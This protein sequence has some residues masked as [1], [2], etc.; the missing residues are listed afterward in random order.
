MLTFMCRYV[1]TAAQRTR[2]GAQY[3]SA[4]TCAS[5]APRTTGT[6]VS[7]SPLCAPPT[8][9]VRPSTH[10]LRTGADTGQSGN[11]I[12][13]ESLRWAAT[14]APPSTS[15]RTVVRQRLPAKTTRPNTPAM[16]RPSTRRN[17]PGAALRMLS[18]MLWQLLTGTW[19]YADMCGTATQTKWS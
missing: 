12:N 6:W 3:L 4:S 1:S 19:L 8:S 2:H 9:T 11:G 15:N 5:I 13:Y 7:T 14:R 18:C 16:P 10:D 17:C